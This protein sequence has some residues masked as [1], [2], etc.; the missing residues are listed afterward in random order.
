MHIL[1]TETPEKVT[2]K[3]ISRPSGNC[4]YFLVKV[5]SIPAGEEANEVTDTA[6]FFAQYDLS[7]GE[8]AENIDLL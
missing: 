2:G 1:K 8:E 3:I 7:Q 6:S 5:D 4:P